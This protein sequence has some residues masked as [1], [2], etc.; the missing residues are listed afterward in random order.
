[1]TLPHLTGKITIIYHPP[2]F[3]HQCEAKDLKAR[4][5]EVMRLTRRSIASRLDP[6]MVPEDLNNL[7][8]TIN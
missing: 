1:M 3:P 2:I 8:A 4:T 7:G 5:L 6:E